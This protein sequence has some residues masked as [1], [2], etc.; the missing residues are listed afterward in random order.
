MINKDE[1]IYKMETIIKYLKN[2]NGYNYKLYNRLC[3]GMGEPDSNIVEYSEDCLKL[4]NELIEI[5]DNKQ[6]QALFEEIL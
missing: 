6:R 1:L 4:I 5:V 2:H 3:P